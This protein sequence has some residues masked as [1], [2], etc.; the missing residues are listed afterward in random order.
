MTVASPTGPP[1]ADH[2]DLYRCL[3]HA[4]WWNE[5]ENRVSSAAFSW[6]VFSVDVASLAG[7][8]QATLDRFCP[9]TGL[10]IFNCGRSREKGC[11]PRLEP[12][13]QHPDNEAH[14]HVYMPKSN[15]KRKK[16]AQH[17][18][19]ICS[20]LVKPTLPEGTA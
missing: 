12:D 10:V 4:K 16:A 13:E 6:P 9:G 15:S 18:S 8:A 5:E 17:L 20:L 3:T 1:V 7:S 19:Q 14:A 11:D 2:E